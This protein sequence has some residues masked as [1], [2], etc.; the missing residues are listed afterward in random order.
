MHTLSE[1]TG[2]TLIETLVAIMV[3]TIGILALYTMQ[4][5]AIHGNSTAG[6]ITRAA[7]AGANQVE[8]IFAMDYDDL[9]DVDG[10]GTGQDANRDGIDD[11]GGNFGLQDAQCCQDGNDPAGNP[12]TGCTQR[13]DGCALGFDGYAVYWNVAV[14]QPMPATKR[15]AVNVVRMDRGTLK[16]VEFNYIKAEVVQR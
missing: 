14:D 8:A 10:D 4:L 15:V 16:N 7:T 6:Q 11:D 12:V 5:S 13:A 3:L 9:V 2:F 1:Q